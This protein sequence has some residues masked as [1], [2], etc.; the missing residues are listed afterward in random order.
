MNLIKMAT[1]AGKMEIPKILIQINSMM[2]VDKSRR[3]FGALWKKNLEELS[4]LLNTCPFLIQCP[5]SASICVTEMPKAGVNLL[6]P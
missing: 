3:R 5:Q 1:C 6:I 2:L 4:H